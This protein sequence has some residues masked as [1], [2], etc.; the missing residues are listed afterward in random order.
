MRVTFLGAVRDG[1]HWRNIVTCFVTRR[2]R[3]CGGCTPRCGKCA[4]CYKP[5]FSPPEGAA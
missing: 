4:W 3:L 5:L 2:H 1:W